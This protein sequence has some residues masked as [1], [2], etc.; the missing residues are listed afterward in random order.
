MEVT[1]VS[2]DGLQPGLRWLHLTDLHVGVNDESQQTALTSLLDSIDANTSGLKFDL[3]ILTGDLVYSGK[4]VEYD[5][6]EKTVITP[7]RNME[8]F[9][10]AIFVSTPGNHDLDCDIGLPIVWPNLG[11]V[12]QPLFFNFDDFGKTTRSSRAAA[13]DAYANFCHQNSILTVDPTEEPAKLLNITIRGN[14]LVIISL[15]TAYFSDKDISDYKKS[16]AP[17][18]PLRSLLQTLE[19][20]SPVIVLGHHP[21]TWFS[22]ETE[23]HLRTLLI[24][25]SVLYLYGHEHEITSQFSGRGLLALG[26]GAVYQNSL[27]APQKKTYRN[28]YAVC[29]LNDSFHVK[30]V[31]WDHEHG[32]WR[33]NQNLPADFIDESN[34]L[35]GAYRLSL[36]T[37]R[38]ATA[39]GSPY[40]SLAASIK[41]NLELDKCIWIASDS[42]K[43]WA[44][45]LSQ[46]GRFR[47]IS[48]T[49]N[50]PT[51]AVAAGHHEF[52]VKDKR[53]ITLVYVVSGSG[54]VLTYDQLQEI[55][56]EL[57]MQDY[58]GCIVAT[59]GKLSDEA[60]TLANRLKTRKPILVLEREDIIRD[61][62]RHELPA[63]RKLISDQNPTEVKASL[64]IT[65]NGV[66]LLRLDRI[67]SSWFDIVNELGVAYKESDPIVLK[68][69]TDMPELRSVRY[70]VQDDAQQYLQLDSFEQ[71]EFDRDV[72][73]TSSHSHFDDVKY[74]PLA[75]LGFRFRKASLSDIYVNAN[76][77]V[78]GNSKNTQTIERAV[79]EFIDSLNLPKSQRDQLESQMRSRL[80]IE[81][82]AE[83]GAAR[84]L[85]QRYN[86]VVVLGDP[87]SGKTCFVKHE[88]LAYCKPPIEG[89]SWYASHLPIY[90]S[91]AEASRLSNETTSL[92]DI[93]EILSARRSIRLPKSEILRALSAG[94]AAFF[95]DGLDEVGFIEKRIQ[96]I[97]EIDDLIRTQA[98]RGNRFVLAS[99]PAAVQP[100]EIPEGLTYLH[101]KGLSEDE[102]R[103]LAGRVLTIRLGEDEEKGLTAEES[104][105]VERLLA[106]TKHS[107]GIA[108]IARNPLLLTLLVL[109]YANTGAISAKRHLIYTQAIKTL[110]SVRG[111]DTRE[112]QISE[113]D[114]RTRLG[115]L[116]VAIFSREIAEIPRRSEVLKILSPI[117]GG[118][119]TVPSDVASNAFLQEVAEA[120]GLLSIHTESTSQALDLITF[121]HY[122]FLEYY[123]AAGLLSRDYISQLQELSS[124]PRWRDV[125]TLMFGILS[126][127]GD[128]TPAIEALLSVQ[129]TTQDITKT[130]LLLSMDCAAECDVPPI[131]TQILLARAVA[132]TIGDG[133]GKISGQMRELIATKISYFLQ[134]AS[135]KF[136]M[137]IADGLASTDP[138]RV[139]AFADLIARLPLDVI[140]SQTVEHAFSRLLA[141]SN[142]IIT[143]A[144]L[145]ALE[146]RN[147]L[148][149][150]E[151]I[152]LILRALRGSL[153]EKHAALKVLASVPAYF[154]ECKE[155]VERLLG[156]P[157][158]FI[159]STA[160]QCILSSSQSINQLSEN[161][162]ILEKLLTKLS[163]V[164]DEGE[165]SFSGVT[166]DE[167]QIERMINSGS[168]GECEL[169][170]RYLPMIRK[171]PQFIYQMLIG[172]LRSNP[173]P[174]HKAA[175]LDSLRS[176]PRA[177]DLI[178]ISDTDI[179]C[180]CLVADE[181]NVRLAATR[182]MAEMPDDEQVIS[183][184]QDNLRSLKTTKGRDVEITETAKALAKHARKSAK[185]RPEILQ[186]ITTHLPDADKGGF[187]DAASQKHF[188]G[189]MTICESLGSESD[190]V[191]AGRLL[192]LAENF[193]TPENIRKHAIRAFGRISF[194]NIENAE[195]LMRLL[196]RNDIKY[197]DATY[198][199]SLSFVS[200]CRRK[201]E[202]IR[203][204]YPKLSVFRDGLHA[205]WVRE[206]SGNS[207]SIDLSGARDIRD[208]VLGIEEI[209]VQYSEFSAR[210]N[211]LK[212]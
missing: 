119:N 18:H 142:P 90:V 156:D 19:D 138:L 69:R 99:R 65:D 46:I 23:K 186:L 194:P 193:R 32:K 70:R 79:G 199:A 207:E 112:Q 43:R 114:L 170:I 200:Q 5:K 107:P 197:N 160:A 77:D 54:D 175:S 41:E 15:V 37:T 130:K 73:L 172:T 189:L 143:A 13:F 38:I 158:D 28:S 192:K 190:N 29:E 180:R 141:T 26:F 66:A 57:D 53:G 155:R 81:R 106:D 4:P 36:P 71:N 144:T 101:L 40:A 166:L 74:A 49:Y 94:K 173:E 31:S 121:M 179:I 116:A 178:T 181:R 95:F 56:T 165:L 80:G 110:V 211:I 42:Q 154:N 83:V 140:L 55:N 191:L 132:E 177:A 151:A 210:A 6:L 135:A 85:Y 148:R 33:T 103:I 45:L 9:R 185:L 188:I 163:L 14:N 195:A 1:T 30:I 108:R 153:V 145:Y 63:F 44:D 22:S 118:D 206:T 169:A 67:S 3:V 72:Y 127:Q 134:G 161:S 174:R 8:Q 34:C 157:N 152:P 27:E 164:D 202:S 187:G 59:L 51:Q 124:N 168:K 60:T 209:I 150:N 25:K 61:V 100:V 137:I 84:Q 89:G 10:E 7:L 182:L 2:P 98:H 125:I 21:L 117:I 203:R 86:N 146:R 17:V 105:L 62:L 212:N 162:P 20:R 35:N 82:T 149:T 91:L 123:A 120:T 75:A 111:R 12:R 76:A 171:D 129:D 183:S 16:M 128:I 104:E 115:A 126:E 204:V 58:D 198:Y 147:E 92:L 131:A 11:P 136:E 24:E 64:I 201:V 52:R 68:I 113:A 50:L 47:D 196:A 96:L 208:A 133:V 48:E 122:S 139:A 39:A 88:I 102:M 93:C 109:I 97:A 205:A 78:N 184:L 159:A 167:Q 87:G 176:S